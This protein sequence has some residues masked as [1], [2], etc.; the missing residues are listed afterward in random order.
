MIG[1]ALDMHKIYHLISFPYF[2]IQFVRQIGNL[3]S[4]WSIDF[5]DHFVIDGIEYFGFE[6]EKNRLDVRFGWILTSQTDWID[7]T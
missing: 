1:K 5:R 4:W 3:F 6:E 2:S 7:A